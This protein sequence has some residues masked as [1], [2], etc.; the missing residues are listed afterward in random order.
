V[1]VVDEI[2]Y[3]ESS[4]SAAHLNEVV[5]ELLV[6]D[7][8]DEVIGVVGSDNLQRHFAVELLG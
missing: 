5:L 2:L 4:H 3:W 6:L 7:V 8:E 1:I